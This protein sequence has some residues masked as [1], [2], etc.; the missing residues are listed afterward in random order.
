MWLLGTASLLAWVELR[1]PVEGTALVAGDFLLGLGFALT[2]VLLF[3]QDEQRGNAVLFGALTVFWLAAQLGAVGLGVMS[4][5][6]V[7]IGALT[8]VTAA[9]VLL[10][11]PGRRL[12]PVA[13]CFVVASAVLVEILAWVMV[14]NSESAMWAGVT[15]GLP[16]PSVWPDQNRFEVLVTIRY[17][18]WAVLGA[19]FLV[20]LPR[21]W[22]R[23]PRLERRLMTPIVAAAT[24]AGAMIAVRLVDEQVPASAAYALQLARAYAAV[25]V[26]G[27]FVVSALQMR[28]ARGAVGD[29][30]ERLAQP[31]TVEQVR[32]ELRATLGDPTLDIWYWHDVQSSYID[33]TGETREPPLVRDRL[34]VPGTTTDGRPLALVLLN[35]DLGRH[36]Q[37]VDSAIAV[38][39]LALENAMLQATLQA[40]LVE[41]RS[42]RSRLLHAGLEQRRHLERDLHDGAQQRLLAIGLRLGTIENTTTDP[43]AA[44]AAADLRQDLREAQDELRQLAHGLYPAVLSQAGLAPA[45]ESVTQRLS[46][47]VRADVAPGRWQADVESAAYLIACECL[48][49]AVKHSQ[50]R[51]VDLRVAEQAKDLVV[52]VSDDGVGSA[53]LTGPSSLPTLRDRV[54]ALGGRLDVRSAPGAGT[55]VTAVLPC[56]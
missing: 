19:T 31:M 55:T 52:E 41:V 16:W 32:D 56:G 11:Y 50:A 27:A 17:L 40:Q 6:L 30:A 5:P 53:H 26:S 42:A 8:Q 1:S 37:L 34:V 36:R 25:A 9:A 24:A 7:A 47:P 13:R 21:H 3:H 48:A 12:E 35:P 22:R 10:R 44:S 51:R 38:S 23:L 4:G 29:L 14:L 20:L 49:N 39:R 28:L 15:P 43:A 46:V 18:L 2:A 54:E 45:L 33:G